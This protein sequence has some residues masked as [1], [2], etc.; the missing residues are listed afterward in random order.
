MLILSSFGDNAMQFPIV[1]VG[2]A[3]SIGAAFAWLTKPRFT[4]LMLQCAITSLVVGAT[5]NLILSGPPE[6]LSAS[7][8]VTASFYFFWSCFLYVLLP[9][10]VAATI[11]YIFRL[12]RQR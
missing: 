4:R 9:N 12:R 10:L 7:Y 5:M 1:V 2:I 3:M 11:V 6:S 8:L